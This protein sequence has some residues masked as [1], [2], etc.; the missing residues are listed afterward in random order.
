LTHGNPEQNI[1]TFAA[2]D[3]NV[4]CP[5]VSPFL[6]TSTPAAVGSN[7]F[8]DKGVLWDGIS[9]DMP[10]CSFNNP[11]WF[12]RHLPQPTTDDIE[13]RVC[14]DQDRDNEDVLIEVMEMYIQ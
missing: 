4:R 10:Y 11:P 3:E 1:W 6:T 9:C 8:C 2:Y 7:Y 14:R 5:D 13:M 12:Y